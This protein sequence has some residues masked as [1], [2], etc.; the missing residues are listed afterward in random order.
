[1][2]VADMQAM[3]DAIFGLMF[4]AWSAGLGVGLLKKLMMMALK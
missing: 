1:M 3:F 2:T 4:W